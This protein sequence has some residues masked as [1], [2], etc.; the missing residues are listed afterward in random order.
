MN[1][2][3]SPITEAQFDAYADGL[4]SPSE[5]EAFEARLRAEPEWAAKLEADRQLDAALR[6]QFPAAEPR[7]LELERLLAQNGRV[8]A[9]RRWLQAGLLA[10]AALAG[11]IAASQFLGDSKLKPFFQ[12]RPVVDIY[13]EAVASGFEPYYEC[14]DD[15]RFA[16]TF[17]QRQGMVLHLAAM[18][19]GTGMLGLSYPGGMSRDT[20]AMLCKVDDKPVMVFVDRVENDQAI[21][22]ENKDPELRI[23][24]EVRDG[25][26]FY[27]VA[28]KGSPSVLDYLVKEKPAKPQAA[29]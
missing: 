6:R 15:A 24:R 3:Q 21:A 4:M 2:D 26:V 7:A 11:V 9:R 28:P 13:H 8:V 16:A 5:R 12:P 22:G 27:E 1:D 17:R 18:P 14:H 20:T 10:A 29:L 19:A 25:L 23:E